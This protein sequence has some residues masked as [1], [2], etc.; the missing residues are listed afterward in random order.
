MNPAPRLCLRLG[1]RQRLRG[2][3]LF[4]EILQRGRRISDRALTV[5]IRPNDLGH[6]RLGLIVG[7]RFGGAVA[8]NRIKRQ[9]R[10]VFRLR[11]HELPA[12]LDVVIRPRPGL[13]LDFARTLQS[14]PALIRRAAQQ[15]ERS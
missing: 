8:R 6:C 14:L 1:P 9:L 5:W 13:Q 2:Q 11:Q 10:E 3:Q 7:R 4:G 12:G 15:P